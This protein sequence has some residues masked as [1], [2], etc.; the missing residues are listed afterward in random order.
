MA[1]NFGS[2]KREALCGRGDSRHPRTKPA[3]SVNTPARLRLVCRGISSSASTKRA[4]HSAASKALLP[5][6]SF[7]A[8]PHAESFWCPGSP[9]RNSIGSRPAW[10]RS[11]CCGCWCLFVANIVHLQ[12]E[13][14][15]ANGNRMSELLLACAPSPGPTRSTSFPPTGTRENP[16]SKARFPF[17]FTCRQLAGVALC[18]AG[19][20]ESVS[21]SNPGAELLF[22]CASIRYQCLFFN[23]GG[24]NRALEEPAPKP[25]CLQRPS[26]ESHE[27][28]ATVV[29]G[30]A[31]ADDLWQN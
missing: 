21:Q 16:G 7:P 8:S 4:V 28:S 14:L 26:M 17:T 20:P 19:E 31:I 25:A 11:C 22:G 18:P 6:A 30:D 1:F 5:D 27:P 29:I 2:G 24:R 3:P 12:I 9:G 23:T 15:P 10:G 13:S